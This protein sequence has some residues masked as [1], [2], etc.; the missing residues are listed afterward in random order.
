M[1]DRDHYAPGWKYNEYE[2]RGV[3]VRLEV[4]PKDVANQA[5]MSVRRDS[6]AKE[7][8]PLANLAERLP[9]LLEE[10]QA[11]LFASAQAYREENTAFAGSLEEIEAHF[12]E[13]RGYVAT[14]W[15][16]DAKFEAEVKARTMATLR[17]VPLDQSRFR[18]QA[19]GRP[20]ALFARA[21]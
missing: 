9:A 3:P 8:I 7:S 4:G 14:P 18:E 11:A 5:V 1:A 19:A 12:R 21:Y 17:C 16:G 6:R 2:M 20:W 15:D 10:I 13:R